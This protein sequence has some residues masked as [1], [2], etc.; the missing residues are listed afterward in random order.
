MTKP[1]DPADT[2][3]CQAEVHIKRS[4]FIMGGKVYET[5]RC[6]NRPVVV[7]T[8][9]RPGPDGLIGS[10]SLCRDCLAVFQEEDGRDVFVELL[11]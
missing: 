4:P 5:Q 10:M 11:V 9:K 1:L 3:R 2:H 6:E 7:V 8:E